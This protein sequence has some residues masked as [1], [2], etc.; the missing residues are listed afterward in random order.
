MELKDMNEKLDTFEGGL[1]D[2]QPDILRQLT[3]N[4]QKIQ[5]FNE[6]TNEAIID[7]NSHINDEFKVSQK[8]KIQCAQRIREIQKTVSDEDLPELTKE[9]DLCEKELMQ[10][11]LEFENKTQADGY[12]L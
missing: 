6:V 8:Y 7:M 1:K 11:V 2:W 10:K 12:K 5:A 3:E 9:R 4:R